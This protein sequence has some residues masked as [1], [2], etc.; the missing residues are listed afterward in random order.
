MTYNQFRQQVVNLGIELNKLKKFGGTENATVIELESMR[1]AWQAQVDEEHDELRSTLTEGLKAAL[2]NELVAS[3]A[4]MERIAAFEA[5]TNKQLGALN[6]AMNDY[7]VLAKREAVLQEKHDRLSDQLTELR[8][9]SLNSPWTA[10]TWAP[11][12]RRLIIP[13]SRGWG[14]RCSPR[15]PWAWS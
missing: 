4:N 5:D 14:I 10:A 13:A 12:R 3:N 1:N 7:R 6:Q 9:F 11:C 2:E 15:S 8:Q